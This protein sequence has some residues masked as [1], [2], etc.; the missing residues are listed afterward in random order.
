M[1]RKTQIPQK[2][3]KSSQ[4][5]VTVGMFDEMESRLGHKIDSGLSSLRTEMFS[6]KG[7]VFSEIS[8]MRGDIDHMKGDINS[9]KGDISSIKTDISLMK[10]E[11]HRVALLV[12]EQNA[13]NKFVLDGYAQL[14]E[15]IERKLG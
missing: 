14:Y 7:E 11:L 10:S 13:R 3:I 4:V 8:S 9:I 12:E 6:L 5:P 15:L 2:P 1:K